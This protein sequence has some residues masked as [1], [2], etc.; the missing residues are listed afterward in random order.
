MAH[1]LLV[2]RMAGERIAIPAAAVESVVDIEA[3]TPVPRAAPHVAG[4]CALRSR[5][6]TVIDCR[7][8]LGAP[9]GE[10]ARE[11]IVI[12]MDGHAFALAVDAVEDVVEAEGG[13]VPPPA[14]LSPEW[15]RVASAMA[16]FESALL[17]VVDPQALI[18]GP[19]LIPACA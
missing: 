5:V 10:P 13:A 2:A 11:G 3:L 4:L 14:S 18:A 12:L 9:A 19:V 7:A 6:L 15:R 16:E 17:L 1:L 8:A